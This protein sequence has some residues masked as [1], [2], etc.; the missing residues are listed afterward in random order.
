LRAQ[1]SALKTA[2]C[3]LAV[4]SQIFLFAASWRS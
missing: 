4:S 1:A 2:S 3:Q